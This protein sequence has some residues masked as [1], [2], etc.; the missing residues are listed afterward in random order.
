VDALGLDASYVS[1]AEGI[2]EEEPEKRIPTHCYICGALCGQTA[3]VKDGIIVS[4]GGLPGDPKGGGRLCPK[5]ASAP[6]HA[7][8]AYRLKAPLI[9]ENGRFRKASWDEALDFVAARLKEQEPAKMGYM[10]GNDLNNWLHEALFDHYGAVKTTHRP[11]C[12]NS[13][14]MA[15]E[16]NLNDKRP[17]LH[18]GDS[19]YIVMFGNNDFATSYSQRKTAMLRAAL[20]RGAKLVVFDPRRS[21]SAAA[22]TEWIPLRPGTEVFAGDGTRIGRV[23]RTFGP[24]KAPYVTVKPYEG[25]DMMSL[26]RKKVYIKGDKNGKKEGRPRNKGRSGKMPGMRKHPHSKGLPAR[27][28]HM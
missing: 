18:Y 25:A 13:N 23:V 11:M 1:L 15:N 28:A 6:N 22:A 9:K 5:G 2:R 8:S 21:E 10:R 19:D 16:H 12:D 27:R 4:M 17:W 14:R 24:E 3:K 7:Y 26:L 20:D